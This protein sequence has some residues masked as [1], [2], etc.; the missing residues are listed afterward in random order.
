VIRQDYIMRQVAQLSQILARILGLR[1][2][3]QQADAHDESRNAL[4]RLFGCGPELA[5]CMSTTQL[6]EMLGVTARR[7]P[8]PEAR[9]LA[10]LAASLLETHAQLAIAAGNVREGDAF[11]AHATGIT[12]ALAAL[13]APASDG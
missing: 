3:G 8:A 9:D 7:T 6:L 10:R 13:D 5:A 11:A 12:A 4:Q 2:A 1:T